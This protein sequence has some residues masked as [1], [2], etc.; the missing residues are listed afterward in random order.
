MRVFVT[1][2]S[3]FIG[4]HV[5]RILVQAGCEVAILAVPGD[6][7]WRLQ[8]IAD[9]LQILRGRL[10]DLPSWE[11]SLREFRPDACIHLAWYT[12]PGKYLNSPE[13]TRSMWNSLQLL[14]ALGRVQCR[15][16]VMVGTCAEYDSRIG[17]FTEDSP[18]RPESL[19]AATK[20]STCLIASHVA[21]RAG[22][23]FA[24]ARLF[25][26]YGPYEDERR[27]IPA[28][29]A[30]LLREASFKAT[31][32][33]QVRDYL[34]VEDV[35]SALWLITRA[36]QV[37]IVNI[38][39]G[40]PV[41]I[42]ELMGTAEEICGRKGLVEFGALPYRDWEPMCIYGDNQKLNRIGWSARYTLREGLA[43]TV[44]WW[45]QQLGL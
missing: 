43:Q 18:T 19:Y 38:A 21:A 9:K 45:R 16:V 13:N 26:L 40:I 44:E 6:T 31:A 25:S 41:T 22:I 35:A 2:A 30:A 12:E 14:E 32:G 10:D 17:H 20:L 7:I 34:H 29:T 4:S 11:G 5:T 28:L 36:C 33:E 15:Q 27:L 8:D 23:N 42:R 37:G 39:S 1:G 3:G 24:W